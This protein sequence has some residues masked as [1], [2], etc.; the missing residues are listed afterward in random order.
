MGC[1]VWEK[2]TGKERS[3]DAQSR[4]TSSPSR[5]N[6]GNSSGRRIGESCG[7]T[8]RHGRSVEVRSGAM[9]VRC[10]VLTL[11]LDPKGDDEVDN[12]ASISGNVEIHVDVVAPILDTFVLV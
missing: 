12:T 11:Y 10:D 9:L 2:E 8:R 1:A 4:R 6:A 5:T 3:V 7:R